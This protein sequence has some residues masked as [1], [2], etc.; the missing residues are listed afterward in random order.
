[1]YTQECL[2]KERHRERLRQAQEERAAQQVTELRKLEKRQQR[3]EREL[4]H[5]WER[6]EQLRATLGVVG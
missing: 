4:L 5:A 1:M 3:A 2:V 6:V